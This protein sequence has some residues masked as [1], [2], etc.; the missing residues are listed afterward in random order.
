MR[1]RS[2]PGSIGTPVDV[3]RELEG[4]RSEG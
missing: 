4:R 1:R 2:F 3:E